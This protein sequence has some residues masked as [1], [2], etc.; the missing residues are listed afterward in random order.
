MEE[1]EK[2]I[3][4]KIREK[5]DG[6]NSEWKAGKKALSYFDLGD[7]GNSDF[8]GFK[9]GLDKFGCVFRENELHALFDKHSVDGRLNYEYFVKEIMD[10]DVSGLS[11]KTNL[12][13]SKMGT[14]HFTVKN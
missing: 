14:N 4:E 11:S 3:Y 6:K 10:I 8:A 7:N 12:L 9:A 1:L 5:S 2:V 13:T